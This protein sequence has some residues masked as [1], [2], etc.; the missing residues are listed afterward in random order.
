[1]SINYIDSTGEGIFEQMCAIVGVDSNFIRYQNPLCGAQWV[2]SKPTYVYWNKVYED[3]IKI[4][5]YLN[6]LTNSNIQKWTAE[7]WSQL[8]NVYYFG[9]DTKVDRQLDF[10][11]A[12]DN[13]E[14]YYETKMLHNAGVTDKYNDLFFKGK[15]IHESPFNEDFS[16]VNKGKASIKYVEALKEVV[17]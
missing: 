11:W 17:E 14:R 9:K 3:S 15:Y 12:T 5:R 2:I 16:F 13:V 7:M 6:S 1:L 4:Y 10:C 8:Y